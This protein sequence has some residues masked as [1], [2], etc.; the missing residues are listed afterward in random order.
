MDINPKDETSYTT[1]YQQA[2]L[3]CV[4]NE[5]C[6]KHRWV[7]VSKLESVPIID[8]VPSATVSGSSQS[9]FVPYD[10]S[11][12]DE[13]YL[14]PDNVAETTPGRCDRITHLLPTTWLYLNSPPEA[15]KNWGQI[16]PNL[17]DNHSDLME[18]K[19]T[20]WSLDITDWWQQLGETYSKYADLSNMA[21]DII[22]IIPHGVRVEARFSLGRDVIG[23][24]QPQTAGE[25][26]CGKSL[27]KAVCSSQWQ[28]FGMCWPRIGYDEYRKLLRNEQTGG[29]KEIARIG[30]G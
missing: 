12:D 26:S 4:E 10:F 22:S 5:Y 13:E 16:Y 30:K 19:I 24:R 9:S 14:T 28:D 7:P 18:I 8:P 23:W 29:G 3:K 17:I 11:S 20:F 15:P 21:W 27:C 6:A 1:Q 25:T 2:F